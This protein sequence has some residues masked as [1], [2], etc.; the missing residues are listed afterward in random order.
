MALPESPEAS[1]NPFRVTFEDYIKLSVK[2]R[3]E[4][5]DEASRRVCTGA[6]QKEFEKGAVWM[7]F[8]GDETKPCAVA[9]NWNGMLLDD[10]ITQLAEKIGYAPF[11]FSARAE[12]GDIEITLA[13]DLVPLLPHEIAAGFGTAEDE[14]FK[15]L[16]AMQEQ[17]AAQYAALALEFGDT[18][19]MYG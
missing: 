11:H 3:D 19:Q 5:S 16:Q 7:M 6:A 4:L 15:K 9:M 14:A 2:E 18:P 17:G 8:C 12:T 13:D 10:E 1:R